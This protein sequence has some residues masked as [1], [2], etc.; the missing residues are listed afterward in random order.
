M[1][2]KVKVKLK[3]FFQQYF[4]HIDSLAQKKLFFEYKLSNDSRSF[5]E[6]AFDVYTN[7]GLDGILL[8][9]YSKIG[10]KT[11]VGIDMAC[12]GPLKANLTNLLLNWNWNALLI[13]GNEKAINATKIFYNKHLLFS[14]I[15]AKE[16]ITAENINDLILKNGFSGE[17]D[18]FSLDVD[19]IDYWLWKSLEV[20][21]PRVVVVEYHD[22]L[23]LNSCTV[24]YKPDF[25]R[26]DMENSNFFGASLSAFNKLAK[27]KG[28]RLIG[29]NKYQF[30]A[31]FIKNGIGEDFFPEVTVESCLTH[32]KVKHGIEHIFPE[33]KDLNW[34][35]I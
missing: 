12:G 8:Y 33:V 27:E 4:T 21:T 10:M 3:N 22:I 5:D 1:F 14:P 28:Y 31:V 23:G 11:R 25:N 9:I 15:I 30:N 26:F 35:E 16:W 20:V 6:V 32:P 18:L 29:T 34:L 24:P 19:G 17:I 2:Y 7:D 13:D